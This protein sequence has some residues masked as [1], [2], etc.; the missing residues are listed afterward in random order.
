MLAS[1]VAYTIAFAQPSTMCKHAQPKNVPRAQRCTCEFSPD[2]FSPPTTSDAYRNYL[3]GTWVLKKRTVF[4]AGG[5][6]GQFAGNAYFRILDEKQPKLVSYVEEGIFTADRYPEPRETRNKLIYDFSDW[7]KVDVFYDVATDRSS[8]AAI[9]GA[10]RPLYSL[11]QDATHAGTMNSDKTSDAVGG[12]GNEV[13]WGG[14]EVASDNSF[15]STWN[16]EGTE[17]AGQIIS[18]FKR[19]SLIVAPDLDGE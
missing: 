7:S 18:L 2:N 19:P 12:T 14:L 3:L 6:N 17:Q 13:F 16:V 11:T 15:L 8:V 5:L 10:A 1:L 9:L 4:T